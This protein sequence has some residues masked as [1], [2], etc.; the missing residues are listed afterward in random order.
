[1]WLISSDAKYPVCLIN[2]TE[3]VSVISNQCFRIR[4]AAKCIFIFVSMGMETPGK[5][6]GRLKKDLGDMKDRSGEAAKT[7]R[8]KY[9]LGYLGCFDNVV[10]LHVTC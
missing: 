7:D 8:E 2:S 3:A 5:I 9:I 1:M 6:Q 4:S 10:T